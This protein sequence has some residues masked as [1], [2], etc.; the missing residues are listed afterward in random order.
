M[1]RLSLLAVLLV[2]FSCAKNDQS[3]DNILSPARLPYL[4]NSRMLQVSSYDTSG[5]NNDRINIPAGQTATL[6]T[7]EGPGVISR[8]WITIDSRDPHF[9]RRILLRF[10]WDD[11]TNP[12]VEVPVGD[13][14]GCGFE[15]RHY[16][17]QYL[18]MTSG[19]YFCYFP[20]PFNKKA[21]IEAVNETG[22]EVF[23]FYYHIGYHK[24]KESLDDDVAYFH[25][26]W[27]RDVRTNPKENYLL[28]DAEGEGHFIGMNMNMQSYNKSLWFLEGD[29]M[30]FV[31]GE[32]HPSIYGTG[33]E[34]Y[35][36]SG[37]YFNRGEYY[38]PFHGM[39]L[40]DEKNSRIV[41]YRHHIFD[42]IPFRKSLRFTIEHGHAND[43]VADYSSTAYWYQREPHNPF[44]PIPKSG[45]R[46]SLRVIV[47]NGLIE[48]ESL[49]PEGAANYSIADMSEFGAE[50]SGFKELRFAPQAVGQKLSVL[51]DQLEEKLVNID[52]YF[53]KGPDRGAF[54]ILSGSTKVGDF[55]GFSQQIMPPE[56]LTLSNLKTVNRTIPLFFVARGKNPQSSGLLMGI[57][58]FKIEP[59]REYIAQWNFIGPFPNPRK[60]DSE[61][62][63]LDTV[64]LPEQEFDHSKEYIGA[65]GQKLRWTILNTP[66]NGYIS[67]YNKVNPHEFV[68]SY[69][70]TFIFSPEEQ[71]VPLLFGSD[72]GCK[73]FLNSN[74]IFRLLDV[75]IAAPDQN[76]VELLLKKGW[77]SL[78]F[79]IEN[80][81]GGYAFFA[82]VID[83]KG[84]LKF[85]LDK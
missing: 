10:Y 3:L 7:L 15:Y 58:G 65:D 29:E 83:W 40:K 14:F 74:Q 25:A 5:G 28:L 72:D 11:E 2:L 57:D 48:A 23:A 75:R 42:P 31:D 39:I 33:T 80:N 49:T 1:S 4:K 22:Q 44:P 64:Y 63:G 46:I 32:K 71:A 20:M 45:S 56:K 70:Q 66:T 47:P 54:D 51:L 76:R 59:K 68:V 38:A 34:D 35:F 19:G 9:L 78:L 41:A 67:L 85:S 21:R 61:R 77:N 17:S 62:F 6:A 43:V 12:S 60:S 30:V 55:D 50:W 82:R 79:K 53:S 8:I 37:W 27:R 18:G 52:V 81:F 84:N 26:Q 13:F 24:L 16:F 73:I 36:T 69:A